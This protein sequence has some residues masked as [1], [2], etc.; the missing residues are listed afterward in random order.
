MALVKLLAFVS[1]IFISKEA[2]N[3]EHKGVTFP[4]TSKVL[5]SSLFH[6]QKARNYQQ[7]L[8]HLLV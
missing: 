3:A 5:A 6:H 7:V 2:M 8:L 4:E 1:V